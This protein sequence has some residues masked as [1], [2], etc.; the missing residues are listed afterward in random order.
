M[1]A[2]QVKHRFARDPVTWGAYLLLGYFAFLLNVLGPLLPFLREELGLSYAQA[3]LH[4]SAFAVGLLIA[5]VTADRLG[6]RFGARA[7]L[8]CGAAGMAAGGLLLAAAPNFPLSVLGALVMGT[9]GSMTLV[10]V[11]AVLARRHGERRPQA[12]AEANAVASVCSVLPPLAVGG[13]VAAGLGWR[14]VLWFAAGLLAVLAG[15][16]ARVGFGRPGGPEARAREALPARYWRLWA[17]LLL[18]V[19]VE[20]GVAFWAADFL[21]GVAGLTRAGA[22]TAVSAFLLAMLLGR[23]AGG[24]LLSR[25]PARRV[26]AL[27]LIVALLGFPVYWLVPVAAVRILG[28]FVTGLGVAN[29]YPALLSLAVGTAPGRE[30]VASARAA[31]ASGLAILLAPFLLG[32]LADASSLFLAQAVVPALLVLAGGALG[33]AGR[34]EGRGTPSGP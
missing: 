1:R 34:G 16:F 23:L 26:V 17:V 14:G 9:L 19:A 22:A 6:C 2:T 18:V 27:S 10:Q 32:A 11:S 4:T 5:S 29:L 20:F 28:L 31:L 8:W 30:D 24:A 12:F 21:S 33:W 7:V 25:L 3:S 13:V 15:V